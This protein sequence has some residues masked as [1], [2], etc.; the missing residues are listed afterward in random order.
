MTFLLGDQPY[1]EW[2]VHIVY[3][4]DHP[5]VGGFEE[6]MRIGADRKLAELR[7]RLHRQNGASAVLLERTWTPPPW[8]AVKQVSA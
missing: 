2:A 8:T 7:A 6:L 1:T 5:K 3:P 4:D